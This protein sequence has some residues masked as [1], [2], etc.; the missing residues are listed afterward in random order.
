VSK[1]LAPARPPPPVRHAEIAI[2]R[3]GKVERQCRT[4]SGFVPCQ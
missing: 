2:I 1:V 3:G 4:E